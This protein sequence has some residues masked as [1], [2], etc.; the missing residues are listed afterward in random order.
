MTIAT[1]PAC[2]AAP[3]TERRAASSVGEDSYRLLRCGE[4]E[5]EW[6]ANDVD[7]A[8]LAPLYE[9]GVYEPMSAVADRLVEPARRLLDRDRLRLL[10]PLPPRARV[11]DVGAG[12]GRMVAALTARG[13]DAIGIEPSAASAAGGAGLERAR[14]E[15]V[16]LPE[17]SADL[18][19]LWHV[20][21]HLRDPAATLARAR[22]WIAPGGRLVVAVPNRDS[23]Q[24]RI[25]GDRWFHQ[26]VPRHRTQFTTRGVRA[27]IGRSGFEEVRVRRVMADQ[28]L[29]GMWLTLL[30]RMTA[31]R[32]VPF[33]FLKRDL[34]HRRRSDAVR[35][36]IVTGLAGPPLA[37][38]AAPLEL[39]ASLGGRGGCVVVEGAP[40]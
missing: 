9:G 4:C 2:G 8:A 35:D 27:L 17:R 39:A 7:D 22:E 26:D 6:I 36:A 28:A 40:A 32:D 31:A 19:V 15:A 23:L 20:A 34:H 24:A 25:G 37:A 33:R 18:V 10:G 5:S 21:E 38:V 30:N 13:H 11:I 3:A 29:L 14:V 12:R 16:S 1:C